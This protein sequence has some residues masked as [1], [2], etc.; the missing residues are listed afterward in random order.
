MAGAAL[1]DLDGTLLDTVPDI[2]ACLCESC[3]A[4]G[5]E[6][7]DLEKTRVCVGNGARVLAERILPVG[8]PVEPFLRDFRA[9]YAASENGLTRRYAGDELLFQLKERGMKLAVITNKPQEAADRVVEQFFPGL[10]DFVGGDSGSF[11]VKPDP[12]LA[13]YCAL[14]L[15]VP[16]RECVFIGDGETDAET[17]HRAGMRHIAVL[18]GYRSK[19]QLE[20]A[21]AKTFASDFQTLFSLL[22][23]FV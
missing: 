12:S 10:F 2:H 5:Y 16:R 22:E 15:R 6:A 19:K 11:P 21:G 20:E 4:F 17:A 14:T 7:P 3:A 23:K 9:R 8:A 18:W 1:F 13:L